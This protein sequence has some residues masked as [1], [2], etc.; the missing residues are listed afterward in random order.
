MSTDTK[1]RD[2][3]RKSKVHALFNPDDPTAAWT[4]GK[5]L[6]LTDGTLRS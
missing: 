1:H 4:L 3:S 6:A 2:G 5:K